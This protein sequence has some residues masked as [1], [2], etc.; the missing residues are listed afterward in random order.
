MP[1]INTLYGG[2]ASQMPFDFSDVLESIAPRHLLVIAPQQDDTFLWAG[3]VQAVADA[4]PAF[5]ALGAD[6]H[7][8]TYYPEGP[9]TFSEVAREFA[10]QWLADTLP[11]TENCSTAEQGERGEQREH[12]QDSDHGEHAQ[13]GDSRKAN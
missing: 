10:Y 2:S 5:V 12:G 11:K 4:R 6:A 8:D 7:L 1:R 13:H 3:V 9:H